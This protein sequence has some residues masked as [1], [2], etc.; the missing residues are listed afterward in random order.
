PKAPIPV[1]IHVTEAAMA[2]VMASD[3]DEHPAA[4]VTHPDGS[5]EFT[6]NLLGG[7][8]P[9]LPPGLGA[10]EWVFLHELHHAVVA[11]TMSN[12]R[13]QPAWLQEG[14]SD[15][16]ADSW[17]ADAPTSVVAHFRI[18]RLQKALTTVRRIPLKE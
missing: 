6:L 7:R 5:V 10:F 9:A 14:L 1:V 13:D 3:K 8:E 12:A 17:F 4:G 2:A 16:M 11:R 15:R 18:A